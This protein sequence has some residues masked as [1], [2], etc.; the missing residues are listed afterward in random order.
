MSDTRDK[1]NTPTN[2]IISTETQHT[3]SAIST[4]AQRQNIV[5]ST[6]AQRSG[7]TP[8]LAL[9]HTGTISAY[10]PARLSLG[11]TA[12]SISTHEHLRFQLDH[13]LARDAVHAEL[14]IPLLSRG[15]ADRNL[16]TLTLHSAVDR[17]SVV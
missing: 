6:G 15:L 2:S 1:P 11:T 12:E 7:E 17:K 16:Q 3:N 5:I 14:D 4:E 13:A 10:T 9:P 8:V